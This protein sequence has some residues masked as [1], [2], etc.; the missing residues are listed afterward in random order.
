[1]VENVE[2]NVTGMFSQ[3]Y[4]IK[5]VVKIKYHPEIMPTKNEIVQPKQIIINQLT[6]KNYFCLGVICLFHVISTGVAS[7]VQYFSLLLLFS[8]PNFNFLKS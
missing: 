4:I 7:E 8:K 3:N 5:F 6:I 2:V 1:M